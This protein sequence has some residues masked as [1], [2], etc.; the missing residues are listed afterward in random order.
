[1]N[2]RKGNK[3]TQALGGLPY[4]LTIILKPTRN[5]DFTFQIPKTMFVYDVNWG[6]GPENT[7][8]TV[9]LGIMKWG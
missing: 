5:Q 7:Q 6:V 4:D 1:M 9:Y 8:I 2:A 3:F